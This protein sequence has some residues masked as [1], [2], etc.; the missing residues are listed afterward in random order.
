[1]YTDIRVNAHVKQSH[2]MYTFV[3][4]NSCLSEWTIQLFFT[5][6]H[7]YT[8]GTESELV[9]TQ[10]EKT[11]LVTPEHQRSNTTDGKAMMSYVYISILIIIHFFF[12]ECIHQ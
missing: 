3:V 12:T 4:V 8:T 2:K 9:R 1:M 7:N 5:L 11:A 10:D 6:L